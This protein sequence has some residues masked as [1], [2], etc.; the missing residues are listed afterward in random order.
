MRGIARS[1]S[2]VTHLAHLA[3]AMGLAACTSADG[4]VRGGEPIQSGEFPEA[5]PTSWNGLYRDFFSPRAPSGCAHAAGCHGTA[6]TDGALVSGFVCSN[7]DECYRTLRTAKHPAEKVAL[8]E[9]SAIADPDSAFL[10][11]VIR[12]T[13]PD[14]QVQ[15]NRGMPQQ[16]SDF[17][18]SAEAIGRMKQWIR[19]GATKD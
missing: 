12:L 11:R 8:V 2:L 3:L 19:N 18:F 6:G 10:F 13:G 17:V 5:S 7:V 15:Q 16:P 14:G 1:S 4:E 9:D